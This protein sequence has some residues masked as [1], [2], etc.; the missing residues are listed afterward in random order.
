MLYAIFSPLLNQAA[1]QKLHS[2]QPAQGVRTYVTNLTRMPNYTYHR[3]P[4]N[5]L[6]LKEL[7][8]ELQHVI[9]HLLL[10]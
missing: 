4:S 2:R 10:P 8:Q 1:H 9:S 3:T 6:T 5:P 7:L